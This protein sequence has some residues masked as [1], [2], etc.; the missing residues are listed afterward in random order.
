MAAFKQARIEMFLQ[1]LDL[2]GDSGLG[3]VKHLGSFGEA[4]LLGNGVKYLQSAVGHD[5]Y[6]L[7][8]PK[9]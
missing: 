2:E 7:G 6:S 4:E 9:S 1:L 8:A 3:H 5:E